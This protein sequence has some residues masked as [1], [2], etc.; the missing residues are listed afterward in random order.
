MQTENA[1]RSIEKYQIKGDS[2]NPNYVRISGE[3]L[4]ESKAIL[5][6]GAWTNSGF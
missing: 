5:L 2:H 4:K 1:L 3:T 6:H